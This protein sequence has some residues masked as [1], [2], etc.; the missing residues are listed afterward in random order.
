MPLPSSDGL[1]NTTSHLHGFRAGKKLNSL[2][3]LFSEAI[4]G[5]QRKVEQEETKGGSALPMQCN[6]SAKRQKLSRLW[7]QS[8]GYMWLGAM[9]FFCEHK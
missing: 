2:S 9:D 6:S 4:N 3:G 1:G 8:G 5:R 7:R